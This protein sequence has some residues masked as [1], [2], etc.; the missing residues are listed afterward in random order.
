MRIRQVVAIALLFFLVSNTHG[1]DPFVVPDGQLPIHFSKDFCEICQCCITRPEL[2]KESEQFRQHGTTL[3]PP[4]VREE[5][6]TVF[7]NF[8]QN[9]SINENQFS[10]IVDRSRNAFQDF[11]SICKCCS[12]K[13]GEIFTDGFNIDDMPIKNY[14]VYVD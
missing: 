5:D 4:I 14:R 12:V 6:A 10:T 2:L 11:C 9:R 8:L 13:N 7:D 1:Q 3:F